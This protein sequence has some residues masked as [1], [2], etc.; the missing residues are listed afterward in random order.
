MAFLGQITQKIQEIKAM[1]QVNEM[2]EQMNKAKQ[3][4]APVLNK[5]TQQLD[6]LGKILQ[7]GFFGFFL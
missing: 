5:C 7:V 4:L 1:P 3:N 2:V 6:T